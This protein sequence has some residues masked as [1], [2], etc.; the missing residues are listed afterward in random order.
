M[1]LPQTVKYL[2]DKSK[3]SRKTGIILCTKHDH[4]HN[5]GNNSH[6]HHSDLISVCLDNST[7]KTANKKRHNNEITSKCSRPN[8]YSDDYDSHCEKSKGTPDDFCTTRGNSMSKRLDRMELEFLG[9]IE[10]VID[11]A[12]KIKDTN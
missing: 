12:I 8:M 9:N 2:S 10:K 4:S 6:S 5:Q 11:P 1:C 7:Q 3:E